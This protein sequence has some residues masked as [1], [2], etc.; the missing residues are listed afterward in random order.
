MR[1]KIT[2]FEVIANIYGAISRYLK[3]MNNKSNEPSEQQGSHFENICILS[4]YTFPQ[5]ES[6]IQYCICAI[7]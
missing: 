1:R 4:E 6:N 2:K 5:S 7:H 3:L